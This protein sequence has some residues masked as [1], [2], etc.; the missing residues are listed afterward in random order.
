M[1][2]IPKFL[3]HIRNIVLYLQNVLATHYYKITYEEI[4]LYLFG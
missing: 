3:N 2:Y 1:L 4:T